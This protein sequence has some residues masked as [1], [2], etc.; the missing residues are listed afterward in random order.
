MDTLEIAVEEPGRVVLQERSTKMHP[1]LHFLCVE[2]SL[3]KYR[4]LMVPD[5]GTQ[6]TLHKVELCLWA[7]IHMY[8]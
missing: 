4:K 8:T 3:E 1:L 6:W 2:E 7:W 5:H